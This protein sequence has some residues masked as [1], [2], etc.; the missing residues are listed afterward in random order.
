MFDDVENATEPKGWVTNMCVFSVAT[1][2]GGGITGGGG[3]GVGEGVGEEI[4]PKWSALLGSRAASV[5]P[6]NTV[7]SRTVM[8]IEEA[9]LLERT[10]SCIIVAAIPHERK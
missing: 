3:V 7:T 1:G 5:V 6:W 4:P 9:K 10:A 8:S 2:G